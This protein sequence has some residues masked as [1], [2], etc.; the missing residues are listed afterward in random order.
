[1]RPR[2]ARRIPFVTAPSYIPVPAVRATEKIYTGPRR[3]LGA[4]RAGRPGE[5][6]GQGGQPWGTRLGSQG[7]DQGFALRLARVFRSRLRLGPGEH[8]ADVVVGCVGVALKRASL[9]GRAPVA[10]DLEMAFGLFGFLDEPPVGPALEERRCLFAE[11]SH[12]HHYTEVRRIVDLVPD[13]TL[14]LTRREALDARGSGHA[15]TP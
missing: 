7:P 15:F 3:R 4:W 11:A 1:M 5:V 14:G 2:P 9:F 6:V 8:V 10:D 12:H 13:A